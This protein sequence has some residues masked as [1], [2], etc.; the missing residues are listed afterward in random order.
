[1]IDLAGRTFD[2]ETSAVVA[3]R[4]RARYRRCW[5][6]AARAVHHLG[7]GGRYVEGWAVVN[8]QHP[9]VIE[10]GWCELEGRIVDPIYTPF[11]TAGVTPLTPPVRY[12]AGVRFDVRQ[13]DTALLAYRLPLAWSRGGEVYRAAFE[14]AWRFAS[15]AQSEESR[16]PTRVVNCRSEP[17]DEFIGRPTRWR[18]PFHIGP[19]GPREQ[20]IAKYR[21][22]LIRQPTLLRSVQEIRGK[23]LGCYCAPLPCHGDVLAEL[24]DMARRVPAVARERRA[25]DDAGRASAIGLA[26]A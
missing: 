23:V 11:V 6:N 15:Q 10:H 5:H 2:S 7:D 21:S 14:A 3:R 25:L 8:R 4:I 20:V 9:Y 17:F 22:W 13:I 16:P 26:S 1:M 19:D 12:F 24:A 18:N